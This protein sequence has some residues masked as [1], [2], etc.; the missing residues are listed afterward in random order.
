MD[1]D[2][3]NRP[4]ERD[5]FTRPPLSDAEWV[6]PLRADAEDDNLL[7]PCCADISHLRDTIGMILRNPVWS[8]AF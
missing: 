1:Q 7:F 2:T 4:V 3:E 6:G 5:Q 8:D